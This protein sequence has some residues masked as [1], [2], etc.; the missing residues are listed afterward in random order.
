MITSSEWIN[1]LTKLSSDMD[2][3]GTIYGWRSPVKESITM[4]RSTC[5]GYVNLA[6]QRA[7]L[8][9]EGKYVHLSNGKLA[10]TGV[11]YIKAHPEMFEIKHV[12]ATPQRLGSN[13]KVGD[14]CLYTV[15]HIMVYAGKNSKGV[16]LWYSLERSSHGIGYRVK[17]TTKQVFSYYSSRRI[18][19]IIRIKFKAATKPATTAAAKPA[20][21]TQTKPAIQTKP[22]T[23]QAKTP[24]VRYKLKMAMNIRK[25]ASAYSAR[26]G[27]APKG[28]VITQKKKSGTWVYCTYGKITGWINCSSDYATKL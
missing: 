1:I 4:K 12:Q 22:A 15:P 17:L 21:T 28:A 25:T 10:G 14:I 20:T 27:S 18:E 7:K 2:K 19:Y 8:L 5:V 16:P 9:P 26:L 13:L 11:S 23:T 6:L 24:V 3:A